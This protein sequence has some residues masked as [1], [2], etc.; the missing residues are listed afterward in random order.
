M[1]KMTIKEILDADLAK[2]Y[3]GED[4]DPEQNYKGFKLLI[5]QG[6]KMYRVGNTIYMVDP[7]GKDAIEWHTS[8]AERSD[9]LLVNTNKFLKRLKA[10]GVKKAFTYYDNPKINAIVEQFDFPTEVN[11]V[12]EGKYKT[13]KAE[14]SL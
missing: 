14:V 1:G 12:N 5:E 2:N 9:A 6:A 7:V 8:N 10:S 13:Y 11:K 3:K 4:F